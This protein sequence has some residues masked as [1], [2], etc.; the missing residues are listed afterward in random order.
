MIWW[1]IASLCAFFVKGLCGFA[2]TLV[3]STILSFQNNNINI[4]PVDLLIGYPPNIIMAYKE[5]KNIDLKICLPLIALIIIGNI[6]GILFLKNADTQLIKI[7]F[8]FVIIG[9]G[10][11]MLVQ[12]KK[13]ESKTM[14]TLIGILSGFLCGLY[15]IGALLAAYVNQ[16]TDDTQSFKGNIC[17]VFTF[18]N[19]F[20]IIVYS[21]LGIVTFNT[22]K[23]AILLLPLMLIG[24]SLGIKCSQYV[25]ETTTKKLVIVML[26][27]S[28]IALI[29]N[30]I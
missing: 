5:R 28:G 21:L 13:K 17:L 4:S 6:P 1:I 15:G 20:R 18:E 23:Q 7:L 25:N 22:I 24:L 2:N 30:N 29:I 27:I 8:G 14:L 3:F 11:E 10:I 12:D 9:I 16:V 19:T 26:I